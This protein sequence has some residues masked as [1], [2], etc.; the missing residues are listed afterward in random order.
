MPIEGAPGPSGGVRLLRAA[1]P[2]SVDLGLSD[3]E[4]AALW[5]SVWLTASAS[6]ADGAGPA[7]TAFE[8]IEARLPGDQR[9]RLRALARGV[10]VGAAGRH[11]VAGTR[12]PGPTVV[13]ALAAALA[14]R[15][16]LTIT[17]EDAEGRVTER[18]VEPH[19]LL[20]QVPL[21]YLL[22]I[23]RKKGAPRSFRLDR[24]QQATVLNREPFASRDVGA[25]FPELAEAGV[26][27]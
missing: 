19:A 25:L 18:S 4:V 12:P 11:L 5:L 23:D 16:A 2:P 24:V 14:R 10:L 3:A 21:W 13:T 8:K 15:C 17:Y 7:V 27:L 9:G 20:V 26:K 22:A 1:A 6:G